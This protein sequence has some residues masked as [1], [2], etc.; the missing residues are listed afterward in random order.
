MKKKKKK[1]K[2]GLAEPMLDPRCGFGSSS[3]TTFLPNPA[4]KSIFNASKLVSNALKFIYNAF[5]LVFRF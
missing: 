3:P 2:L 1:K 5:K 4:S